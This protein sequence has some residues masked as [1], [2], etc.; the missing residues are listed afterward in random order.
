LKYWS[1][2]QG[3]QVLPLEAVEGIEAIE[4][5][6]KRGHS[7]VHSVLPGPAVE[8]EGHGTQCVVLR[9]MLFAGHDTQA[10]LPAPGLTVPG[11]HGVHV[12]VASSQNPGRHTHLL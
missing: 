8:R 2:P 12:R 10:P 7:H 9:G 3:A 6:Q 1:T 4:P 11:R 5:V